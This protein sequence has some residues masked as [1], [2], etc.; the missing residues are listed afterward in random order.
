L[1]EYPDCG[2]GHCMPHAQHSDSSSKSPP[3]RRSDAGQIRLQARDVTGLMTLADMY[4]APYDL[5]AMRTGT[6]EIRLRGVISR[7]RRAGLAVTGRL[8]EG[9]FWCWLTPAGMRQVGHR[10]EAA[11][12]PLARLAHI[13]A[14]L[15]ARMWLE[16]DTE[17]ARGRAYW[18]CERRIRDGRAAAG[19]GH[20]PDGEVIWPPLASSA[21]AGETWCIEVELTPKAAARTQ[22]IMAGLLAQPYARI[23]YLAAPAA[24]PVLTSAAARF[25]A[26]QAARVMIGEL[27]SLALMPRAAR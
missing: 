17:W 9:P 26:E 10:W 1:Y 7:W 15:A 3:R 25:R 13:R 16:S 4:A 8:A 6:S 18:R 22:Q 23:C 20:L 5:L 21:R 24:I 11:P 12:P 19:Q 27:P 2:Y 14:V